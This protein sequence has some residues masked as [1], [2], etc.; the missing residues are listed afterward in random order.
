[1]AVK[2]FFYDKDIEFEDLGG[3]IKRKIKAYCDDL[4]IVEVHFEKGAVGSVHKHFHTQCTYVLAGEFEF[5]IDGVKKLVKAGDSI[6]MQKDIDHGAVCMQKG[7]LLD[8]F[9][10]ARQDFLNK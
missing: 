10:P 9:T 7:I 4:M 5:E 3:G 8:I 6:H 2:N 1:M